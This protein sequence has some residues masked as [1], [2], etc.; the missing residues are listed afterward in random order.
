M[1]R[2][3]LATLILLASSEALSADRGCKNNPALTGRCFTVRGNVVLTGDIGP[4]F[5]S[6]DSK[7]RLIIRAAPNSARDMPENLETLMDKA[8]DKRVYAGVHGT[9][10]VCPIPT[11]PSQFPPETS[12]YACINSASH[13]KV[14]DW[15]TRSKKPVREPTRNVR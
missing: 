8:L 12:R 11:E 10:E 2:Q 13:M 15:L 5:D 9:Y 7:T 4:A 3:I 14:G 1:K 6:D